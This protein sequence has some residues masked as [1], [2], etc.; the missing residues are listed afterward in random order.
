VA[1]PPPAARAG[2]A[3]PAE[4]A[5]QFETILLTQLLK[6]L[7]KTVPEGSDRDAAR[8]LYQELQDETLAAH[9]ARAGGIGIA[10]IVRRYLDAGG[11]S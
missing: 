3:R 6:G 10:A 7:R 9:L 2:E 11:R 5:E 1:G 8:E 4:V